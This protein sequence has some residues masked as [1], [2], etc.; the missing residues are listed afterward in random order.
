MN[1]C[2][3]ARIAIWLYKSMSDQGINIQGIFNDFPELFETL[4]NNG[5]GTFENISTSSNADIS[6]HAVRSDTLECVT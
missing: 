2:K 4:I 3:I 5:D 1:N 6:Y